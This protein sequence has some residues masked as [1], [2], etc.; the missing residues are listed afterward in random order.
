VEKL[1]SICL[2]YAIATQWLIPALFRGESFDSQ[3]PAFN[4]NK[5]AKKGYKSQWARQAA[6][7]TNFK[8]TVG[9]C[10]KPFSIL[11]V[12][13]VHWSSRTEGKEVHVLRE[14]DK[15]QCISCLS[16]GAFV[17]ETR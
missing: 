13:I 5:V 1:K 12:T 17:Q 3:E 7:D 6:D 4:S 16:L 2:H 9:Y 11:L 8:T 14:S 15:M 10:L